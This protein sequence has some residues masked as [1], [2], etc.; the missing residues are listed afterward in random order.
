MDTFQERKKKSAFL[1]NQADKNIGFF[2]Q[3]NISLEKSPGTVF[4]KDLIEQKAC[5]QQEILPLIYW[6]LRSIAEYQFITKK[7]IYDYIQIIKKKNPNCQIGELKEV[8]DLNPRLD[9]ICSKGLCR[10]MDMVYI[11][12]SSNTSKNIK[13]YSITEAGIVWIN[14][15]G[16]K[17]FPFT[18]MNLV[19]PTQRVMSQL[20]LTKYILEIQKKFLEADTDSRLIFHNRHDIRSLTGNKLDW[21][22]GSLHSTKQSL[23]IGFES[24]GFWDSSYCLE[25]DEESEMNKKIFLMESYFFRGEKNNNKVYYIFIFKDRDIMNAFLKRLCL[26]AQD[27]DQMRDYIQ[28]IFFSIEGMLNISNGIQNAFLSIDLERN[29]YT[30]KIPNFFEKENEHVYLSKQE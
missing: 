21:I 9:W 4:P 24:I 7:M 5:E 28:N 2:S 10:K 17:S 15:A 16:R 20:V 13:I 6:I 14:Q 18:A 30:W 12:K 26:R 22:G 25:Q 1:Y 3:A 19:C 8:K 29:G 23:Y 27:N 11:N